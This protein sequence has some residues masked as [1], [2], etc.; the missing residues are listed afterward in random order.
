MSSAESAITPNAHLEL[1]DR[2]AIDLVDAIKVLEKAELSAQSVPG[3][4]ARLIVISARLYLERQL[5]VYL[6]GGGLAEWR[7]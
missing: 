2:T 7:S 5:R 3:A 1:G 4:V 6:T